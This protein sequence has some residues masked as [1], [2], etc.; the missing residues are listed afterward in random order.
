MSSH[1][2]PGP[3]ASMLCKLA[4]NP[5]RPAHLL[6]ISW[7]GGRSRISTRHLQPGW[8]MLE[9]EFL[10]WRT[11]DSVSKHGKKR[12]SM[13]RNYDTAG[14]RIPNSPARGRLGARKPCNPA[15]SSRSSPLT[16]R[17]SW[18]DAHAAG[19]GSAGQYSQW[20]TWLRVF[21]SRPFRRRLCRNWLAWGVSAFA[22]RI[23]RVH[24]RPADEIP[25][26]R[27]PVCR[28]GSRP[29]PGCG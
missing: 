5:T 27:R 9:C 6:P 28:V 19:A 11:G 29:Q 10:R 20:S 8:P 17:I 15:H 16:L 7:H 1:T 4:K 14:T 2:C 12:A 24:K 13:S 25:L 3:V 26:T 21:G 23:N 22:F 18:A